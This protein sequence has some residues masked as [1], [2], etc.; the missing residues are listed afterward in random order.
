MELTIKQTSEKI[1]ISADTLRYYEKEGII[2]PRHHKNGY[3]YYN[4]E[5]I[6]YLKHIAVMEYA[7]FSIAEIRTLLAMFNREP[8]AECNEASKK[9][10][11]NKISQLKQAINNYQNIVELMEQILP[12]ISTSDTY[13]H[14]KEQINAFINSIYTQMKEGD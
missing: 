1:G 10:L 5:N 11:H 9:I 8:S 6:T 3:R 4:E 14:N 13:Y 2:S 12:M 7:Q